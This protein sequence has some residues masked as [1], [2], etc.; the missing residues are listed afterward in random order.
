MADRPSPAQGLL[1]ALAGVTAYEAGLHA[2]VLEM[3]AEEPGWAFGGAV[4]LASRLADEVRRLGG[5]PDELL[6]RVYTRAC[7]PAPT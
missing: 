4:A 5:D 3:G 1:T 7:A 2:E 6:T